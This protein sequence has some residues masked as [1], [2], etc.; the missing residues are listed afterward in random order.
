MVNSRKKGNT[1]EV[2]LMNEYKD[3]GFK[4]CMTS[5]N[6][7]KATDDKWIDLCYTDPFNIQAKA[8]KSFWW[9][10]I[11]RELKNMTE[12]TIDHRLWTN[13]NLVHLKIDRMGELVCISKSDWYEILELFI[14]NQK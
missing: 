3:L 12:N 2:K 8:Y 4:D 6:E 11:L 9:A 1:Y 5:R 14:N 7:S 13:Y 10:Q